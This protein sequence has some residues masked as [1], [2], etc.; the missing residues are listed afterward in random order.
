MAGELDPNELDL[1]PRDLEFRSRVLEGDR[2][3]Y[4]RRTDRLGFLGRGLVLDVGCGFGQWTEALAAS[5]RIVIGIDVFHARVASASKRPMGSGKHR[6]PL[7]LTA[8]ME[9]LPI[10]SG[11]ADGL[12]CYSA[13]FAVDPRKALKEFARVAAPGCLL[14]VSTN[15]IGWYL[16]MMFEARHATSGFDPVSVGMLA[17][18]ES[19]RFFASGIRGLGELAIPSDTLT[20]WLE[21][22]G[23]EVLGVGPEGTLGAPV[24]EGNSFFP[25]SFGG[26]EAVYEVLARRGCA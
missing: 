8:S 5:N 3:R 23:F 17:V 20:S 10:R 14:Y 18:T 25:A 22:V 19:V 11:S 26:E 16:N 13:L 24:A 9:C 7:F 4:S 12:F 6:E 1:S 15:A 21:Q 2:R